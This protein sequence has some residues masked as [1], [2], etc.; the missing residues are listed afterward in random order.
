MS[1]FSQVS[2]IKPKRSNHNISEEYKLSCNFGDLIPTCIKEVLP[3]DRIKINTELLIKLAPLKA[4]VMHRINAYM[5]YFFV[6][7]YQICSAFE[8][9]VNPKINSGNDVILPELE[10]SAFDISKHGLSDYFGLPILNTAYWQSSGESLSILPFMVYQHVYNSYY[11]DQNLELLSS[12]GGTAFSDLFD[13]DLMRDCVGDISNYAA[14]LGYDP[15]D[16]LAS[17]FK[18]RSRAWKKDYFTSALPSPQAGDDV[19][20]PMQAQISADGDLRLGSKKSMSDSFNPLGVVADLDDDKLSKVYSQN[21]AD[22]LHY[23]GGLKAINATATIN[24]LRKAI[25]LQKVKEL[26]ERGGTRYSEFVRNFFGAY[27]PDWYVDRPIYLGG[28]KTP[29]QIGEV[30]QTS[31]S[32]FD[33]EGLVSPQGLR[34]GIGSAYGRTSGVTLKAPCHGFL[35]G[36]LSIRPEATYEQGVERMWSR[37]SMFDYPFPQ[38]ANLGEQEIY[39]RELFA[40]AS[41]ND[42]VFGYTPRY[43][44]WKEGHT[45]ICGEFRD[46]LHY[47]HFGRTFASA[48]T[49]S[50]EFVHMDNISYEPFNVTDDETE[51]VYVDLYNNIHSN[52]PLP[53]FGTPGIL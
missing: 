29:L 36:I 43:A 34:A 16:V 9:F 26:A 5:H 6:P 30:V 39:Q 52:R 19:L 12:E 21:P 17:L 10:V 27:L 15:I 37:K 51:H 47:W 20:I 38:F 24:D 23:E 42:R 18:L 48:P 28:Q 3:S 44:E 45:H 4:P 1:I 22:S 11:R 53:F 33:D 31:Q 35:I 13:V 41:D 25:Q 32:S 46:T 8:K 49:L 50:K 2:A 14:S 40:G 7:N